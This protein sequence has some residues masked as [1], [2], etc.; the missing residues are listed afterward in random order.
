M[1]YPSY[2][3]HRVLSDIRAERRRQDDKWGV[4]D[5]PDGTGL[6]LMDLAYA[7]EMHQR[8]E[9][10]AREGQLTW[11][12]IMEEK[13]AEAFAEADPGLVRKK[14]VQLAAIC[15][16]WVEDLDTRP[17]CPKCGTDYEQIG[18]HKT[19]GRGWCRKCASA[20]ERLRR[21]ANKDVLNARRRATYTPELMR[22]RRLRYAYGITLADERAMR[23]D[24][25]NA[26]AICAIDTKLHVDH[27]HGN[28]QVRGLL[29]SNCNNGLGRFK[30]RPEVLEM[31]AAYLRRALAVRLEDI[32][33]RIAP[34]HPLT[35]GATIIALVPGAE[36]AGIKP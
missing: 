8:R 16:A 12:L 27:D 29:C 31:A 6:T 33:S 26:C 24:Q 19:S 30:D 2:D 36:G 20:Y 14:L 13:V 28:G 17:R 4:R 32:D 23:E 3:H 9:Q 15:V 25:G 18:H 5:R 1:S 7:S 34:S 21:E 22:D 35:V 10:A 11:S